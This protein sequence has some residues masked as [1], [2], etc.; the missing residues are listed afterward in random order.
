MQRSLSKQFDGFLIASKTWPCKR[1]F[2]SGRTGWKNASTRMASTS[3]KPKKTPVNSIFT[4]RIA[5]CSLPG[6]TPCIWNRCEYQNQWD[7]KSLIQAGRADWQKSDRI[8]AQTYGPWIWKK[9]KRLF[10]I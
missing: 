3:N 8:H 9:P 1:R 6:G 4:Y 5:R 10:W 7:E 2:S